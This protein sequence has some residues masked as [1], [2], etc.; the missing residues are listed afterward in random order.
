MEGILTEDKLTAIEK[1]L[2]GEPGYH[3]VMINEDPHPAYSLDV[4]TLREMIVMC[5]AWLKFQ[6]AQESQ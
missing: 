6:S 2:E 4:E 5:R 3:W 1:L